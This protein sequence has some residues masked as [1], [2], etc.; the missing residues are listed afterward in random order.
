MR[1]YELQLVD[2]CGR[3]PP[4]CTISLLFVWLT[5][6]PTNKPIDTQSP[7]ELAAGL[8]YLPRSLRVLI[9]GTTIFLY[10]KIIRHGFLPIRSKNHP[11]IEA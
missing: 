3:F 8:R 11:F 9:E 1:S 4:F 5:K 7:H 10:I 6:S 2:I